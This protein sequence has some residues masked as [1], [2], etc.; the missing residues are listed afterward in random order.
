MTFQEDLQD[1]LHTLRS[2]KNDENTLL[3]RSIVTTAL[4]VLF[5]VLCLILHRSLTPH[6]VLS[7]LYLALS[8]FL[9]SQTLS[10]ISDRFP[11]IRLA[12]LTYLPAV[13]WFFS[14]SYFDI[15]YLGFGPRISFK[16]VVSSLFFLF[17]LER[18][19]K[20]LLLFHVRHQLML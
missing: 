6:R 7:V 18:F 8:V 10:D 15:F 20:I 11:Q 4:V 1:L 5:T 9:A 2:E 17:L 12:P 3:T 19:Q 14:F 13:L 16:S